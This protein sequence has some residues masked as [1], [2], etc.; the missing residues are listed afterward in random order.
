MQPL[1]Q[2]EPATKSNRICFP[3][4]SYRAYIST[5]TYMVLHIQPPTSL[6]LYYLGQTFHG[7]E[8]FH[9][10]YKYK[11]KHKSYTAQSI[12]RAQYAGSI[13]CYCFVCF[14]LNICAFHRANLSWLPTIGFIVTFNFKESPNTICIRF[15]NQICFIAWAPLAQ[16]Y[17]LNPRCCMLLPLELHECTRR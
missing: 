13:I 14:F 15:L 1:K 10:V 8:I 3:T 11:R 2:D 7:W 16:C 9:I 6:K 12:S 5:P 4:Q 17:V